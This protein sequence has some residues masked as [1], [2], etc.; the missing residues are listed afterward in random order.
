MPHFSSFL[1]WCERRKYVNGDLDRMR[2]LTFL[3]K[4]LNVEG[5]TRKACVGYK[6]IMRIVFLDESVL[7]ASTHLTR[8]LRLL[9]E[10][11]TAVRAY[12]YGIGRWL[13]DAS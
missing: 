2:S 12:R 10:R 11:P 9:H 13:L 4:P 3:S 1:P 6:V 8:R 5:F 7:F